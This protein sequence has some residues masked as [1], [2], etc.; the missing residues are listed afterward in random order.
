MAKR[1]NK[2][3]TATL[4]IDALD[5][6]AID[7]ARENS[8]VDAYDEYEQ[9]TGFIF[10]AVRKEV[11][12]G[13]ANVPSPPQ[14]IRHHHKSSTGERARV[15]GRRINCFLVQYINSRSAPSS[16]LR[17]PSPPISGEKGLVNDSR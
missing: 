15:R 13:L 4:W 2:K 17:P 1:T 11:V 8:C 12:D 16:G 14:S 5:R 7:E 9:H 3:S 10:S 6:E